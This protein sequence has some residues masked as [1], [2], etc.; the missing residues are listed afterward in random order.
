MSKKLRNDI[1]LIASLLAAALLGFF[2]MRPNIGGKYV[3][4]ISNGEEIARYSLSKDIETDIT[5]LGINHLV[6]KDG[7]AKIESADCKNQVCV[8]SAAISKVGETIA[9][10]PHKLIIKIVE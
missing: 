3:S 2:L 6:I 4:V 9:C 10:L 7:F 5:Q 8:H 1:I